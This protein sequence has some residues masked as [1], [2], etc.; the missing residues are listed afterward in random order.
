MTDCA[1]IARVDGIC[2]C[3]RRASL[4]VMGAGPVNRLAQA[5]P[6]RSTI[7]LQPARQQERAHAD[8]LPSHVRTRSTIA[9]P[10]R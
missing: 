10:Q 4:R 8:P 2:R 5:V 7:R 3:R 6:Q 9:Q 1:V